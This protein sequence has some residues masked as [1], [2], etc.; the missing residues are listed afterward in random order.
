MDEK[1]LSP[2]LPDKIPFCQSDSDKALATN[3]TNFSNVNIAHSVG[4]E[5]VRLSTCSAFSSPSTVVDTTEW[6]VRIST[7]TRKLSSGF[8]YHH[9]LFDL[10]LSPRDWSSFSTAV[11]EATKLTFAD[12]AAIAATV[13]SIA[14]TTLVGTSI[15]AGMKVYDSRQVKRVRSVWDEEA[16]LGQVLK[17]WNENFFAQ[18][19]IEAQLEVSEAVLRHEL[20]KA[21]DQAKRKR[22]MM[23]RCPLVLIKKETRMKRLEERKFVILLNP[24]GTSKKCELLELPADAPRVAEL[25]A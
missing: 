8:P 9:A 4:R 17:S 14:I 1:I 5:Y 6:P 7:S 16:A 2:I 23:E 10:H 11:I 25:P 13:A 3:T 18:Y 22:S 12:R 21:G 19:G 24:A 15:Y 20:A